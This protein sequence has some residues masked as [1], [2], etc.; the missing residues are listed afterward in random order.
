[1]GVLHASLLNANLRNVK[2]MV[3]R[4]LLCALPAIAAA[5]A[6]ESPDQVPAGTAAETVVAN[7]GPRPVLRSDRS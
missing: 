6:D 4:A 5:S 3:V 1:M 2:R 7:L